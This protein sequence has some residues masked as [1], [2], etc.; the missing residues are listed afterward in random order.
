MAGAGK[1]QEAKGLRE[2][3]V[4]SKDMPETFERTTQSCWLFAVLPLSSQK[5]RVSSLK[6]CA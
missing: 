5:G 1:G 3:A 6:V 2:E 4:T